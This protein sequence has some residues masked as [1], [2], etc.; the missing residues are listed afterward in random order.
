MTVRLGQLSGSMET[1]YWNHMEVLGFLFKSAQ[2]LRSFPA[3]EGILTWLPLEQA[4]ATLADLLLRDAPDCHPVYHVDN[5]V[6]KPWAEIVPVLAQALG[7]PEKGIVPLDDWLRRVKAFPGEDPWDNPAGKA[8]DFF[9]HKFQ[10][11][12]C[13]GV[14]MATNNAVEH[15]PTLRGVQPV[16]DAVVMKYFQVWKDTGF[17]R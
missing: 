8:I 6:R 9:E 15:S 7:I 16:A 3:V 1:G 13:G 12:S 10:H 4:S 11:M 14:T 5:P 17:L 2:T